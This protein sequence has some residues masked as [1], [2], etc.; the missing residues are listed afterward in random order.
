VRSLDEIWQSAC[1][2]LGDQA[3]TQDEI[4]GLL[5]Q[6]HQAN[7]LL[8]D[9]KPDLGELAERGQR[10][11][12]TRLKQYL[13]NPLSLKLP[14]FDPDP[15]VGA[16]ARRVPPAAWRGIL[17]VWLA[18]ILFGALLVGMHWTRSP[19]T[20]RRG[21]SRRQHADPGPA[22]PAAEGLPRVRPRAGGEG[23][24]RQLPRDG[25][26]VLVFIPV[27]WTPARA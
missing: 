26:D 17:L 16:I 15:L 3:P 6:L 10:L 23:A 12:R 20:S 5:T 18:L 22:V 27:P 7:V 4:L 11:R 14:L 1:L 2:T 21:C 13:A 25:A 8:T 19:P 9:R 24:G